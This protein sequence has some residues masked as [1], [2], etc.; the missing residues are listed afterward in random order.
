VAALKHRAAKQSPRPIELRFSAFSKRLHKQEPDPDSAEIVRAQVC[1]SLCSRTRHPDI[2][3]VVLAEESVV[4]RLE[5]FQRWLERQQ[6]G[7]GND[8][9]K[10]KLEVPES[11][12]LVTVLDLY[13]DEYAWTC[14]YY[15]TLDGEEEEEG[16]G[17]VPMQR[18]WEAKEEVSA[19]SDGLQALLLGDQ[20]IRWE[21]PP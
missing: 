11:L 20:K 3:E 2:F 5:V 16:K 13:R 17:W 8:N 15:Q 18:F 4:P 1:C 19:R 7:E 9:G 14:Q 21:L 6:H 10:E 12:L